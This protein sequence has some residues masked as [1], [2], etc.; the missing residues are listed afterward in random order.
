MRWLAEFHA[1]FLGSD[2]HGLWAAGTYW[3]L[4]T[5]PDELAALPEGHAL[6]AAAPDL[7]A[8]L[9]ACTTPTL[10]HGDA[11]VANFCFTEDGQDVAAV[12]FQYV[13]GGCGIQDVAYFLGSCLDEDA[14]A[15]HDEQVL[16]SYFDLL[17]KALQRRH[18]SVDAQALED[19]WRALY[20][21]AWADFCRFLVGWA[22]QHPKLHRYSRG[23]VR[24]ALAQL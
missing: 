19:E 23:M 6:H 5:R 2:P 22:P 16:R 24:Q 8:R 18:S 12:D 21:V 17:R 13:G 1:A 3:H 9:R 7:D 11:K 14:C 15:R 20:P 10:V 4:A